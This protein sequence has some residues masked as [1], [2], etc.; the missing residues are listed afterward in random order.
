MSNS[1]SDGEHSCL[2]CITEQGFLYVVS[3]LDGSLAVDDGRRSHVLKTPR[4]Y[5]AYHGALMSDSPR[6]GLKEL[7]QTLVYAGHRVEIWTAR[8]ETYREPTVEWL[9]K[10]LGPYFV[11]KVELLMRPEGDFR[12]SANELKGQW[13]A[14][15]APHRPDLIFDDRSKNVAFWRELGITCCQVA[16]NS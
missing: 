4:D 16:D 3:D 12:R 11:E 1:P 7:L 13:L 10:H 14:E 15:A 9:T 6:A 5:E 8:P 2:R